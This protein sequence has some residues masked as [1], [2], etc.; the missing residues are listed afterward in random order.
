MDPMI[1]THEP[2]L[3][4]WTDVHGLLMLSGLAGLMAGGPGMALAALAGLSFAILTYAFRGAWTPGGRYGAANTL[5]VLRFLLAAGLMLDSPFPAAA[6]AFVAALVLLLDGVD[7]WLARRFRLVSRYGET[8]DKEVD[9]FFT[10]ALSIALH[11][12]GRFGAWILIPGAL[13]YLFVLFIRLAGPPTTRE[14][15]SRWSRAIGAAMLTGLT[16]SLLPIGIWAV[17]IAGSVTA[18]VLASFSVSFWRLYRP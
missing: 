4:A 12:S 13:R 17:A 6:Q 15:A 1:R 10:L 8:L 7:G 3:R 9:A 18:A 5:T 14:Q 11:E 2:Q 16:L